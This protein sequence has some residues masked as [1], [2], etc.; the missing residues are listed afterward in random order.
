MALRQ[1][2]ADTMIMSVEPLLVTITCGFTRTFI[3]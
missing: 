2:G 3:S 1:T